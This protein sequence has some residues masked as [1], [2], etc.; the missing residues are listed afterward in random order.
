MVCTR[1]GAQALVKQGAV[2]YCARCALARDWEDVIALAQQA[3]VRVR[4]EEPGASAQEPMP[5]S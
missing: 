2:A 3:R 4:E 5:P 1:C